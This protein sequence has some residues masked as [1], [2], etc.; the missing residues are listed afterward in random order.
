MHVL[1]IERQAADSRDTVSPYAIAGR[2]YKPLFSKG[3]PDF[4]LDAAVSVAWYAELGTSFHEGMCSLTSKQYTNR[5]M[6]STVGR[7]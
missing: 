3:S 6:G 2:T 7:Q 4:D 1:A 5:M